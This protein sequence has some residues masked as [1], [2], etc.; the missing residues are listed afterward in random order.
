MKRISISFLIAFIISGSNYISV[1]AQPAETNVSNTQEV[2]INFERDDAVGIFLYAQILK[3]IKSKYYKDVDLVSCSQKIL[4]SGVSACTDPYSFY[5]NTKE[6]QE[7]QSDFLK[8]E[9]AGIG[10][11]LL[12]RPEDSA[13]IIIE[14]SENSPAERAGLLAG[15]LIVAI[16]SVT[17]NP[18]WIS[19]EGLPLRSVVNMIRGP[20]GT[21]VKIKILRGKEEKDFTLI[22]AKVQ[23]KFL[24]SKKIG[25]VGYVK[26]R[27]FGGGTLV[28]D[29]YYAINGFKKENIK[30]VIIDLRNN[31][32]GLVGSVLEIASFFSKNKTD[33]I[34][35]QKPKNGAY[36]SSWV[37]NRHV[38]EF[39]DLKVI[40]LQNQYSAS[41]SEILSGYLKECGAIVIGNKSFGKG[42][43]QSLLPLGNYGEL[44]LTISEYFI[45]KN[46]VKVHG[47]GISTTIE[48][49]NPEPAK[50]RVKSKVKSV[51]PKEKDLQLERAL[52]E[53]KKLEVK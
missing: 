20:I 26:I 34:L 46:L 15:D 53:A 4:K 17:P 36:E 14:V 38:S 22:R 12:I 25:K 43:V 30:T 7:E 16:S 5:L 37:Y 42:I 41:A 48:V 8:A 19:F 40:V 47:I 29:F 10:A 18:N 33:P 23:I 39:K 31:G 1:N 24:S 35:F 3:L 51:K 27:Q 11:T 44:H 45:G 9:I 50:S 52:K 13:V 2:Q 21:K 32:G 49:N 6:T 28:N